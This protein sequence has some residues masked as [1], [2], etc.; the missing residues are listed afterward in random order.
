MKFGSESSFFTFDQL[1]SF[2][3]IVITTLHTSTTSYFGVLNDFISANS[4]F[5]NFCK[6][7]SA[8]F[9]AGSAAFKSASASL[10]IA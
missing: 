4:V 7:S 6:P 5:V 8:A 9:N 2:F 1:V 10:V 3:R